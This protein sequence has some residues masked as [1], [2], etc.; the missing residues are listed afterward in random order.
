VDVQV[1]NKIILAYF[2]DKEEVIQVH[3]DLP[4]Y[5]IGLPMDRFEADLAKSKLADTVLFLK[6]LNP[7]LVEVRCKLKL[8]HTISKK[9]HY[10]VD[11]T[12][13]TPH[14]THAYSDSGWDLAK[15]FDHMSHALKKKFAQE[16]KGAK[17]S[18]N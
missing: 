12:L 14:I 1:K 6:K 8:I 17:R 4:A 3:E 16:K 2:M 15:I 9:N 10:Q 18:R 5:I 13:I 7:E 11:V